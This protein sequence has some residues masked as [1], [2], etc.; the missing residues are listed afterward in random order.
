MKIIRI[1]LL[2]LTSI[3]IVLL[4]L[5]YIGSEE[6]LI[7]TFQNHK[8]QFLIGRVLLNYIPIIAYFLI[9]LLLN[10]VSRN[11]LIKKDFKTDFIILNLISLIAVL[12]IYWDKII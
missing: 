9:F 7:E 6:Q 8:I 1:F 10:I 5:F 3:I 11:G 2:I 12:S 4:S